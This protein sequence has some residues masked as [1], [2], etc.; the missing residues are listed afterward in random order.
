MATK[1]I[2]FI[3]MI[4]LFTMCSSRVLQVNPKETYGTQH[5]GFSQAVISEGLMFSSGQVAWDSSFRLA[6]ET[7]EDQ[8]RKVMQNVEWTLREGNASWDDVLHL[9]FYVV[10]LDER[11]RKAI[12][13]W[14]KETYST[15]FQPATTLI[16][17]AN[18]AQED[19]LLEVEFVSKVNSL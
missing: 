1:I 12:G 6:G 9:R 19:L 2:V 15:S 10:R 11:A 4:P 17:I 3:L 14:L 5:L 16:G 18:L 13:S 8:L 7:F